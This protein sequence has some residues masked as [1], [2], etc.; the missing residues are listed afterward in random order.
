MN[1]HFNKK[2]IEAAIRVALVNPNNTININGSRSKQIYGVIYSKPIG[3]LYFGK[4][5]ESEPNFQEW[6]NMLE[7]DI[8]RLM[9]KQRTPSMWMGKVVDYICENYNDKAA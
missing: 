9:K 7:F 8:S 4:M 6:E 1:Q 5:V 3:V 2:S